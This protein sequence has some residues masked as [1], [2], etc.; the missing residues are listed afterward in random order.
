MLPT[1]TFHTSLASSQLG[2]GDALLAWIC[3]VALGGWIYNELA[4]KQ[5][6]S[7]LT[8][9]V[10]AQALAFS[11]LEKEI[12]GKRSVA[13][14]SG[15]TMVMHA[16]KLVCRISS[17]L[18]LDG[19][20][21][22]DKSG[23]WIY[24]VGDILSLLLV[25]QI[26]F[27][28]YV[29]YKGSYQSNHDTFD[30]RNLIQVAFVLAMLVHPSLNAWTPFDVLWAAHLYI[31]AVA[32]VPQLWMISRAGGQMRG[33]NAHYIVAT[34][35]SSF[36]SGTFWFY[37]APELGEND[38]MDMAGLAVIGAHLVQLM[39]IL[40]VGFLYMKALLQ[41]TKIATTVTSKPPNH[42]DV[43]LLSQLPQADQS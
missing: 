16:V 27:H 32:M 17:T 21:P 4:E 11:L 1:T 18:L 23:D 2:H 14:I 35:L 31:D 6:T 41:G 7:I 9:S 29:S 37:A 28:I 33:Y 12:K 30:V 43:I 5:F 40:D 42:L 25:F 19:Y 34:L 36:L 15:G 39:L 8:L 10:F 38:R 20:K 24:Q 3:F 22:T 26:L 13:G